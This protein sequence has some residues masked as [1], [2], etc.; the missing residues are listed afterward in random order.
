MCTYNYSLASSRVYL[1]KHWL[2]VGSDPR[3]QLGEGWGPEG[4][5]LQCG[6][7]SPPGGKGRRVGTQLQ[8]LCVFFFSPVLLI[9]EVNQGTRRWRP[10]GPWLYSIP[11][12]SKTCKEGPWTFPAGPAGVDQIC[13]LASS[14]MPVSASVPSS[15]LTSCAP[16]G[17]KLPHLGFL[18]H[19]LEVAKVLVL[20]WGVKRLGKCFASKQWINTTHVTASWGHTPLK[21]RVCF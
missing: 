18:I 16:L 14:G 4:A 11:R 20:Q 3:A 1:W 10:V 7:A 19:Q 2:C 6:R 17:E 12:C 15:P 5:P 8:L 21:T 9:T 13:R